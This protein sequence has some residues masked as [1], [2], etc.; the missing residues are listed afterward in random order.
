MSKTGQWGMA[1]AAVLVLTA[2]FLYLRGTDDDEGVTVPPT[3]TTAEAPATDDEQGSDKPKANDQEPAPEVPV[4]K[5]VGGQPVGGD[6]QELSF[7]SG[8]RIL[9][10]VKSDVEEEAHL[11]GYDASMAIA[12]GKLARFDVEATIEGVFEL[13]LENSG[14]PIAEIS[15]VP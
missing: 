4:I 1:I 12:P 10:D 3:E 13:E 5:V 14:V 9:F 8:S 11:H 6:V 2:L 15:V 7:K